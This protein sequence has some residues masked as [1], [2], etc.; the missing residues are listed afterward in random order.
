MY[1]LLLITARPE[2]LSA[3][4]TIDQWEVYG[5]RA[6]RVC[7]GAAEA[8]QSLSRHHADGIALNLPAEEETAFLHELNDRYPLLPVMRAAE[9]RETILSDL[10]EMEQLLN[11]THAD[12]SN[13][14][15]DEA[16]RMLLARHEMFHQVLNGEMHSEEHLTRMMRLYRS[17]MDPTRPCVVHRLAFPDEDGYLSGHWAYGAERLEVAMRNIF[18][19]ELNGMRMLISVLPDERIYLVCCPMTGEKA[20]STD[21]MQAMVDKQADEAIRHVREYLNME[22]YTVAK[23][24]LPA[25]TVLAGG[26]ARQR[27]PG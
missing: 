2:V 16:E 22:L 18:G 10:G 4:Q 26:Q 7:N 3:F 23:G 20:P 1:K 14:R 6:P 15:Y 5:F 13:D 12:Y 25:L 17:R 11:Q 8:M 9:E 24:M 21:E 19:A 27:L